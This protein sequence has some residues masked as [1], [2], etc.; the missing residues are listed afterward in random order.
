MK[1]RNIFL[2]GLSV[3]RE[4]DNKFEEVHGLLSLGKLSLLQKNSKLA[5]EYLFESL[6]VAENIGAKGVVYEVH[7]AFGRFI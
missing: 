7:E 2:R 3:A 5:K 4:I 6:K 1:Q